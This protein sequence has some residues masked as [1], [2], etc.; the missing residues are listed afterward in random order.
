MLVIS[1]IVKMSN[2][3]KEHLNVPNITVSTYDM[4]VM[5]TLIVHLDMKSMTARDEQCHKCFTA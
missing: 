5:A 3:E 2:V 1:M 4:Y